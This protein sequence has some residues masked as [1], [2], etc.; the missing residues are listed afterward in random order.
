VEAARDA[1][2]GASLG[3]VSGL[4][5]GELLIGLLWAMGGYALF[6]A[7]ESWARRGGLQEAY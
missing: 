5:G 6:R 3:Q 1:A 4:I 7:L 2:T